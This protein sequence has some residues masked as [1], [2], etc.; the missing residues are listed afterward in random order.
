[1]DL[2][3]ANLTALRARHPSL[4]ARL[5]SI[6]DPAALR[7]FQAKDGGVA[8]GIRQGNAVRP[9]TDHVAPL[10]RLQEQVE[11]MTPQLR[12]FTRPIL[13]IGLYPGNELVSLFDLSEQDTTPHCAQPIWVCLDSPEC[14]LG[15]LSCWDA[16]H[17]LESERVTL[18]WAEEMPE[19]VAWLRN[20]P[21]FPH[22]FT[23]ITG[24]PDAALSNILPPLAVLVRERDAETE[25]LKVENNA[26][27]DAITD[28][29]L[30]AVIRGAA[31]QSGDLKRRPRL[32]MP[33]C[34]WSTF[35]Q[36]STRDT[37]ASFAEMGWETRTLQMDAML[38]PYYLA[39]SIN[40]FKPDVFLFIDHL[41]SEAEEIYPKNM[42]FLTWIQDEMDH[43]FC[44]E[45]GRKLSEYAAQRKRDLVVGYADDRLSRQFEY[46]PDRLVFLKIP[47][48]PKIFRP[49]DLSLSDKAKYVCDLA[50]MTNVSMATDRI[51]K[52][53]I[54]PQVEKFGVSLNTCM[55]IHDE[56][57][58]FYRS[59]RTMIDRGKFQA[60]LLRF[61]EFAKAYHSGHNDA[62]LPEE[63]S[64]N[65]IEL[66]R[67]FYW[68]LNDAIFRHVVLEWASETDS[69][70]HLYGHGWEE[71]PRFAKYARG[72]VEHGPEL[73]KA[74]QAAKWCLHL[75][76]TQG[77][78]QRIWEI[79]AAGGRPLL[80]HNTEMQQQDPISLSVQRKLA[81]RIMRGE[82]PACVLEDGMK[83]D[84]AWPQD[85]RES[86]ADLVFNT[87]LAEATKY[88]AEP[89]LQKTVFT[90]KVLEVLTRNLTH[91]PS[92][93]IPDYDECSFSDQ[94]SFLAL[95]AK[96]AR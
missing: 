95:L 7:I 89:D 83:P 88:Q 8:F 23:L 1:M 62:A 93:V 60:W 28:E 68:R 34:A 22:V 73:S 56:L 71:H 21:A 52:D 5:E 85:E 51:V 72:P 19:Q 37:C 46:P 26:Y 42:M 12:D 50:F 29:Q 30:A 47:A 80:R 67:L 27:Y 69:R 14:L 96:P 90:E 33:T 6:P 82:N 59:G 20:N 15:F 36:Y 79:M 31:D 38:T 3:N 9:L 18:F 94:A 91:R 70:I 4:A 49:V 55:Q 75:N 66:I 92:L 48:D 40:E 24:A 44:A 35:I 32:M 10:K 13:I 86:L 54:A 45:A 53:R 74:Y 17:I 76:I 87:A 61:P 58:S 63:Q 57:W 77:M 43:L 81:A 41:R 78:H 65:Q 25:R 64:K 2:L 11:K 16:R 84:S 39:R